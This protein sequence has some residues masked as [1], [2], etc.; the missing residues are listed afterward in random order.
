MYRFGL[1]TA[2]LNAIAAERGAPLT[3][4][5]NTSGPTPSP[6]PAPAPSSSSSSS[7]TSSGGVLV[8]GLVSPLPLAGHEPS[9]ADVAAATEAAV[10]Q[11]V[12]AARHGYACLKIKVARR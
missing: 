12:A 6:A 7:T 8:N 9:E 5:L 11:A 3:D 10:A 1:E 4:L 2:I